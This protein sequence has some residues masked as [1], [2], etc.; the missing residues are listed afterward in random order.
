MALIDPEATANEVFKYLEAEGVAE[1]MPYENA[2]IRRVG[3][4]FFY[5]GDC[6]LT[7]RFGFYESDWQPTHAGA[8]MGARMSQAHLREQWLAKVAL[9]IAEQYSGQFAEYFCELMADLTQWVRSQ[10]IVVREVP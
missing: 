9:N 7:G 8:L 1:F 2:A 3:E 6:P 10:P 5:G 4:G